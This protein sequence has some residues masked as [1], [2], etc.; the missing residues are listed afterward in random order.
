MA[1]RQEIIKEEVEAAI[2][3]HSNP[4]TLIIA[5]VVLGLLFIVF[6]SVG[7]S[8]WKKKN[9]EFNRVAKELKRVD[10]Q[11]KQKIFQDSLKID[12]LEKRIELKREKNKETIIKVYH[13]RETR[14]KEIT[15]PTFSNNDIRKGFSAN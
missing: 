9:K 12:S 14:I 5:V 4:K 10:E 1:T 13:E 11:F 3:K 8:E 6:A 7:I 15:A 2:K